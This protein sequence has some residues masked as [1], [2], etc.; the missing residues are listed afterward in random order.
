MDLPDDED[1][2]NF[3]NRINA[4]KAEQEEQF[5]EEVILNQRIMDNLKKIKTEEK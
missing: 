4:L 3:D 2:F 1:D 5:I